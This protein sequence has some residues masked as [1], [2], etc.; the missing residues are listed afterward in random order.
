MSTAKGYHYFTNLSFPIMTNLKIKSHLP[1]L[2]VILIFYNFW[3]VTLYKW[4][5]LADFSYWFWKIIFLPGLK[6]WKNIIFIFII[7]IVENHVWIPFTYM[8]MTEFFIKGAK[9]FLF[10]KNIKF[11][12]L[13]WGQHPF[14]CFI[15]S[16]TSLTYFFKV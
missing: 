2:C 14:S 4:M 8:S 16:C 1:L 13:I 3:Q 12:F 6:S 15:S 10:S 5:P 9:W 11:N 7:N